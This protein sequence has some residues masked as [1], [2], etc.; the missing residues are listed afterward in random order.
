MTQTSTPDTPM[1]GWGEHELDVLARADQIQLRTRR[2]DGTS[3]VEVQL[4]TVPIGTAVLV[5]APNTEAEWYRQVQEYPHA[6]ISVGDLVVDV[7]FERAPASADVAVDEAY[8][9]KYGHTGDTEILT[10]GG[11]LPTTLRLVPDGTTP[12]R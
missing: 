1:R 7:R 10:S 6:T 12:E 3:G 8:W 4:W 2:P 9:E 11:A 5:R